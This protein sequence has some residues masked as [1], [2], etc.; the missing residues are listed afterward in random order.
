MLFVVVPPPM[1]CQ[2]FFSLRG[3]SMTTPSFTML[4]NTK[5]LIIFIKP[6]S[7]IPVFYQLPNS[8]KIR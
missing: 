5:E 3:I 4:L 1:L 8:L 2:L 7:Y 6:F